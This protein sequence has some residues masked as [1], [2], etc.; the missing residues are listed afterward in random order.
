MSDPLVTNDDYTSMVFTQ[1]DYDIWKSSGSPVACSQSST[2][3]YIDALSYRSVKTPCLH[4]K[5]SVLTQDTPA[6]LVLVI[7]C[8]NFAAN[9]G[10]HSSPY[11]CSPSLFTSICYLLCNVRY[12]INVRP[13]EPSCPKLSCGEDDG[14]LGNL[15][16][17]MLLYCRVHMN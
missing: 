6:S 16:C 1:H 7:N 10:V 11:A 17:S 5:G 3:H 14:C 13:C 4:V 8:R 2:C 15:Q 12:F 9:C